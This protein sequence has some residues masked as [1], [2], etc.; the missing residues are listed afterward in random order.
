MKI[1][2]N[3][4]GVAPGL[5]GGGETFL[6]NLVNKLVDID[7]E[8]K[9][10]IIVSQ[11]N[12]KLF[13][14]AGGNIEHLRYNF[15]NRSRIARVFFEQFVMPWTLRHNKADLLIAPCYTGLIY[16]PCPVLL[17]V[18]DFVFFAYPKSVPL[19][20]RTFYRKFVPYSCRKASKVATISTRTK[21]DAV[22]YTG[23]DQDKISVIYCGVD[24][25]FFANPTQDAA[26]PDILEQYG[27][28]GSYIFSPTSLYEHN[29]DDS[30][31]KAFAQLKEKYKVPHKLVITGFDP[32]N[33]LELLKLLIHELGLDDEVL[34]LG[35]VPKEHM[36]LLYSKA[37]ITV[38]LSA[39][40]GFGL[41]VVEAMAAGCPV[42][43]S[44]RS[45]LP[46]V[47]GDAGVLVDSFDIDRIVDKMHLL[48]TDKELRKACIERGHLQA[49]HFS[50]DKVAQNLIDIYTHL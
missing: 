39:Y 35:R 28:D 9:L 26:E 1:A 7:R 19:A 47:V 48:L 33:R 17:I 46:E 50:W 34:Y 40:T 11:S 13:P 22:R 5:W 29:K 6:V 41:P 20:H 36:P 25:E 8:N 37:D 45:C 14:A 38:W 12:E 24:Y 16:S 2:I 43:S 44:D 3:T 27:I 49:K 21:E 10:L 30:L 32:A 31:V 23:I 4:L 42:L 15:D 18:L